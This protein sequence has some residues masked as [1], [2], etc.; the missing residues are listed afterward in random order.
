MTP[1]IIKAGDECWLDLG[2][3]FGDRQQVRV[4]KIYKGGNVLICTGSVKKQCGIQY[5][6]KLTTEELKEAL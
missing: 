4:V 6:I 2:N 5:L 1:D 3:T